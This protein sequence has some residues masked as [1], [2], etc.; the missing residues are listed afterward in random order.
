MNLLR[1]IGV[2]GLAAGFVLTS[3]VATASAQSKGAG[4]AIMPVSNAALT[5]PI[6]NTYGKVR[7][8]SGHVMT[9]ESEGAT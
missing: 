1:P 9:I 6:R 3:H 7:S 4:L 5:A 2:L 8:L